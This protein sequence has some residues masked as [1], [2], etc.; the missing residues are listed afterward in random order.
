M[1]ETLN[2]VVFELTKG[3]VLLFL[4]IYYV[5]ISLVTIFVTFM[6]KKFAEK[7]KSRVPEKVLFL[8]AILGGAI[9]EFG[10]MFIIRH[11][12]LHKRFMIG[13][14]AI[15][16]VQFGLFIWLIVAWFFV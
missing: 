4:A 7:N 10:T 16:A 14:P 1:F 12:T 6:D 9:C 11:K 15:F 8:L 3:D 2:D 13:L 5:I